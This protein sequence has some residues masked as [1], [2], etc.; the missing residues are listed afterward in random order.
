[1]RARNT[2]GV[3]FWGTLFLGG[4]AGAAFMQGVLYLVGLDPWNSWIYGFGAALGCGI[5][6]GFLKPD[7]S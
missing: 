2:D 1:M 6:G 3:R 4:L 7:D 5:A